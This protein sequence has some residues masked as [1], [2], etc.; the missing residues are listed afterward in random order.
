V[1][2]FGYGRFVSTAD[3]PGVTLTKHITLNAGYQLASH[4]TV[5]GT[6][7]RLG[8]QLS[9]KGPLVGMEFSF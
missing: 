4:L 9:L 6:Q 8:L 2:L 3:D 1:Y 5:N 7:N